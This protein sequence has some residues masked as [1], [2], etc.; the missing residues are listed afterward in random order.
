[1]H[2]KYNLKTVWEGH[3]LPFLRT[4]LLYPN[5]YD[6]ILNIPQVTLYAL[7]LSFSRYSAALKGSV[8]DSILINE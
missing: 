3:Y 8:I 1:M 4:V 5:I 7:N 6:I 2:Q